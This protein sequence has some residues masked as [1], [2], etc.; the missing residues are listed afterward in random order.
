M[1]R[2]PPNLGMMLLFGVAA[3]L[4]CKPQQPFYF[5]E[6]GDLSR[7]IGMA[8]DI[9]YPDLNQ[10]PL[11]EVEGAIAPFTLSNAEPKEIWELKL[12]DAVRYALQNSKVMRSIGGQILGPP[13]SLTAERRGRADDLRS[14][15]YG[16]ECSFRR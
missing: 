10:Q 11:S 15:H 2:Q 3:L 6:K 7:Y 13:E 9:D 8:T 5:H 16:D 4:G 14:G 12:E 1:R